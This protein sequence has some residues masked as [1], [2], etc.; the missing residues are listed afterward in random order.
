[1]RDDEIRERLRDLNPWWRAL[2]MGTDATAWTQSDRMLRDRAIYDLGYRSRLLDDVAAGP[3]DDKLI[4]LRGAR[5]VGK[6]VLLKDTAARLC[7]RQDFDPR[8]LIYVS[9]DGMR[10]SDFNR[11]VQRAPQAAPP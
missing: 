9:A 11:L 6:S 7:A 1:M 2:A 5:R 4:V 3:I 10:A 8:Q